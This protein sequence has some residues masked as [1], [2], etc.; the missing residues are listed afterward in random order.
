MAAP[1]AVSIEK[2][3]GQKQ[4]MAGSSPAMTKKDA[5]QSST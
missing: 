5:L 1:E 3:K 4:Q 2:M